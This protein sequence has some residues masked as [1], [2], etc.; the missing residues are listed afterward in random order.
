MRQR[1]LLVLS[2]LS[3]VS[4]NADG[5]IVSSL[6][7][8]TLTDAVRAAGAE[9]S[10][11]GGLEDVFVSLVLL[12]QEL[13]GFT[14]QGRV[15]D[16][17]LIAFVQDDIGRHSV[18]TFKLDDI[19][20]H[21]VGSFTRLP[22]TVTA[23]LTFLWNKVLEVVHERGSLGGLRVREDTC[24]ED[25][26]GEHDTQVKVGL[27]SLVFLDAVGDEAEDGTEP[28]EQREETCLLF[29]EKDPSGGLASLSELVK[30]LSAKD[31]VGL[32]AR[33]TTLLGNFV[34]SMSLELILKLF[35][36]PEMLFLE[37]RRERV[38]KC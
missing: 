14:S 32:A 33:E 18:A 35:E 36:L 6:E 25:H 4:D 37:K 30:T 28:E 3:Q 29:Q 2:G 17:E 7:D 10:D 16:L 20:G 1:R 19:T 5:G 13:L 31:F 22:N 8:D 9:E 26:H 11:V 21:E 24:D 34:V 23:H 15:V 12:S 27:V 38:S